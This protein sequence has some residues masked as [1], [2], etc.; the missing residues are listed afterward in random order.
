MNIL[1]GLLGVVGAFTFLMVGG[2]AL[3]RLLVMKHVDQQASGSRGACLD[4]M[5][6]SHAN[7]PYGKVCPGAI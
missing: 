1:L 6:S 5:H 7:G 4:R 3:H 2:W